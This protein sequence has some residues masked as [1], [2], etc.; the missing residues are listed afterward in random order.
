MKRHKA[1]RSRSS[2]RAENRDSH[3]GR[4]DRLSSRDH[5]EDSGQEQSEDLRFL[6]SRKR[7]RDRDVPGT[8]QMMTSSDEESFDEPRVKSIIV[9]ISKPGSSAS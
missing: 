5:L 2:G 4:A 8:S 1:S 9:K 6:I 7:V 3:S